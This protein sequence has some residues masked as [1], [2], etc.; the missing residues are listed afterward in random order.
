MRKTMLLGEGTERVRVTVHM[1]TCGIA[2]G[3]EKIKE[4]LLDE[5]RKRNMDDVTLTS[6]GCAGLCSREPMADGKQPPARSDIYYLR[7]VQT[8]DASAPVLLVTMIW[9]GARSRLRNTLR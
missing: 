5:F 9:S 7:I 3:A 8:E 6:S 4:V 2:A 1:G